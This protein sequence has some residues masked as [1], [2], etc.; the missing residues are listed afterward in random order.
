MASRKGWP[1]LLLGC[2]LEQYS[3]RNRNEAR[4]STVGAA[5]TDAI[6]TRLD[7]SLKARAQRNLDAAT[8]IPAEVIL[9]A[10]GAPAVEPGARTI[11]TSAADRI[12][13]KSHAQRQLIDHIARERGNVYAAAAAI[14]A[15]LVVGSFRAH[16][17]RQ[18]LRLVADHDR[19]VVASIGS[20]AQIARRERDST[21]STD[22]ER[23][24]S[25]T[26][27]GWRGCCEPQD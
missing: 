26:L 24:V 20:C 9:R 19:D 11:K 4:R 22:L 16:R 14:E 6:V 17:N 8:D 15:K 23:I 5:D 1:F 2:R 12:G 13:C 7:E 25:L 21:G 3:D 27:C 10:G 18:Q